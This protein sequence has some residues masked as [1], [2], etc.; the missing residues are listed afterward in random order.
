M[1]LDFGDGFERILVPN[2]FPDQLMAF[3]TIHKPVNQPKAARAILKAWSSIVD[4]YSIFNQDFLLHSL[5]IQCQ[6]F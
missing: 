6:E 2:S 3:G 5:V 4:V 1:E